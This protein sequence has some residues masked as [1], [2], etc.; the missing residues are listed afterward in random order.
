[1]NWRTVTEYLYF[2]TSTVTLNED[3]DPWICSQSLRASCV[4]K[5]PRQNLQTINLLTLNKHGNGWRRFLVSTLQA[6]TP[7]HTQ[8]HTHTH[9]HTRNHTH[10]ITHIHTQSHTHTH[11][12]EICQM[13]AAVAC[14]P[15]K[16]PTLG[17][18]TNCVIIIRSLNHLWW[19]LVTSLC[20]RHL[21]LEPDIP[22][23]LRSVR[24]SDRVI[25]DVMCAVV[26]LCFRTGEFHTTISLSDTQW[27]HALSFLRKCFSAVSSSST[28]SL[29][30]ST[31]CSLYHPHT[32][33]ST[34]LLFF[35]FQQKHSDQYNRWWRIWEKQELLPRDRR[36]S[37]AG[38]EW[39]ERW[40]RRLPVLWPRPHHSRPLTSVYPNS[41]HDLTGRSL[42]NQSVDS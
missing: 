42:N 31:S 20:D 7:T 27:S 5:A 26:N 37:A 38:D 10:A 41:P 29:T 9:K 2:V 40:G 24:M 8:S 23:G 28:T 34:F 30:P 11:T 35:L 32:S 14:S 25:N 18:R 22:A 39:E 3:L 21:Q 36:A 4:L 13:R 33:S 19:K 17:G 15:V 16:P 6:H 12:L 1:M